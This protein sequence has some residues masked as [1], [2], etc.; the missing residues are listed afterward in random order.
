[1]KLQIIFTALFFLARNEANG[2]ARY[3]VKRV[4]LKALASDEMFKHLV[5]LYRKIGTL[6]VER[7][8]LKV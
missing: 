8:M 4:P 5:T 7:D 1:M 2:L 6:Q 3:D